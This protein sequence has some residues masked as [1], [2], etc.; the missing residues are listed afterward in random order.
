MCIESRSCSLPCHTHVSLFC[1]R[2]GQCM[3]YEKAH[4]KKPLTHERMEKENKRGRL[5]VFM[6][7]VFSS[8]KLDTRI[9]TRTSARA[10]AFKPAHIWMLFTAAVRAWPSQGNSLV[11]LLNAH[12]IFVAFARFQIQTISMREHSCRFYGAAIGHL[13]ILFQPASNFALK[14]RWPNKLKLIFSSLRLNTLL[15]IIIIKKTMLITNVGAREYMV[16]ASHFCVPYLQPRW[17]AMTDI[18]L[19]R[20]QLLLPLSFLFGF[21]LFCFSIKSI[22]FPSFK[23]ISIHIF[24]IM[25]SIC[26]IMWQ[27]II[28]YSTQKPKQMYL[29]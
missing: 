4:E 1:G 15:Q 9:C 7:F 12:F 25:D 10:H 23:S 17:L 26:M 13:L 29:N 19:Q 16:H 3:K 2:I 18:K 11:G 24:I 14:S 8:F 21:V 5:V 27:E 22:F 20:D 28:F 6:L